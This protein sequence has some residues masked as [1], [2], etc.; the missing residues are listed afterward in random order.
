MTLVRTSE[1]KTYSPNIAGS[2]G[3]SD[4]WLA[5]ALKLILS[6]ICS[7]SVVKFLGEAMVSTSS[8]VII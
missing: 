6:E 3:A 4:E 7:K 8:L 5:E 1:L 2:G